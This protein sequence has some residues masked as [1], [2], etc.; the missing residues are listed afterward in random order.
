MSAGRIGIGG[1]HRETASSNVLIA[2]GKESRCARCTPLPMNAPSSDESDLRKKQIKQ[3]RT[4]MERK[5]RLMV[6]T[7]TSDE[8]DAT[9]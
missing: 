1:V 2:L 6:L 5:S 4:K 3:S 9:A 8:S 7:E